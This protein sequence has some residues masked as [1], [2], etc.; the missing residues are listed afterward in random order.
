MAIDSA[1]RLAKAPIPPSIEISPDPNPW[2]V[3]HAG[4][5]FRVKV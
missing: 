2:E 3:M 4:Q 5:D 1:A